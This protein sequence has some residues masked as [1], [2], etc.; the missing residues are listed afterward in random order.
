MTTTQITP[1][2][3]LFQIHGLLVVIWDYLNFTKPRMNN[4]TIPV[5]VVTRLVTSCRPYLFLISQFLPVFTAILKGTQFGFFVKKS[6]VMLIV[7]TLFTLS[8]VNRF[9]PL[10]PQ[11]C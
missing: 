10:Y 9:N 11:S 4:T 6:P 3:R 7:L 8:H 1:F 5:I 2:G